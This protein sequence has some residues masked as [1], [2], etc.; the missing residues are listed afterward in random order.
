M[1]KKLGVK[2]PPGR[3]SPHFIKNFPLTFL[4]E[5]RFLLDSGEIYSLLRLMK[6]A[7]DLNKYIPNSCSLQAYD[8][9][10]GDGSCDR[11]ST[12]GWTASES[13]SQDLC[14]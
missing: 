8:D 6:L 14:L 2:I 13:G 7:P 11:A 1:S 10:G 9:D 5:D 12:F 4:L 3:I